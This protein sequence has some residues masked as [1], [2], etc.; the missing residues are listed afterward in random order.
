MKVPLHRWHE[1][2]GLRRAHHAKSHSFAIS[3]LGMALGQSAQLSALLQLRWVARARMGPPPCRIVPLVEAARTLRLGARCEPT[4]QHL[5]PNI[6]FGHRLL[7]LSPCGLRR[8]SVCFG[9]G[10]RT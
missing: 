1:L 2:P 7:F 6:G 3:L 10:S 5:Q 8:C 9:L 4:D